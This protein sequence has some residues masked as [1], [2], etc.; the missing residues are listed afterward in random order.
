[1]GR[2]KTPV[3]APSVT[4]QR[5]ARLYR[6]LALTAGNA[7]TRPTLQKKLKVD[8][9][10]FYR[11]LE[12]LRSLGVTVTVA[13]DKYELVGGLDEALAKL[14]F[15]DPGLSLREALDLA[16]NGRTEAHKKLRSRISSFIGTNGH[17]AAP[18]G[19]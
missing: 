11:D 9:R 10:G 6:L 3:A 19:H 5:A 17:H 7:R 1:M 4:A 12:L 2:S 8:V 18:R 13:G 14:P 15:P 16:A